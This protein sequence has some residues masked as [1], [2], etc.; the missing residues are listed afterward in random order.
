MQ[1]HMKSYKTLS[2]Y[3]ITKDIT[4]TSVFLSVF[5]QDFISAE[6]TLSFIFNRLQAPLT[7]GVWTDTENRLRRALQVAFVETSETLSY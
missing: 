2:V 4:Y 6:G 7:Q 3:Y 1:F 5:S